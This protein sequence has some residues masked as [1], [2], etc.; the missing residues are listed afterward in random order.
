MTAQ[1][2]GFC[3]FHLRICLNL[4]WSARTNV[5]T[6]VRVPAEALVEPTPKYTSVPL[7]RPN[8]TVRPNCATAPVEVVVTRSQPSRTTGAALNTSAQSRPDYSYVSIFD[9][10]GVPPSSFNGTELNEERSPAFAL[11]FLILAVV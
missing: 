11:F 6:D 1:R 2:T 10:S 3:Y 5:G 8:A 9:P 4:R 7:Y